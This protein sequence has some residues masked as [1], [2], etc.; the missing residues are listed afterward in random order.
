MQGFRYEWR[1]KNGHDE[2]WS[3]H[4]DV[5]RFV[6][7]VREFHGSYLLLSTFFFFFFFSPPPF[8]VCSK[9]GCSVSARPTDRPQPMVAPGLDA[10]VEHA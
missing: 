1:G 2:R 6:E 3:S 7:Y 8:L 4:G 5:F 10:I 9:K